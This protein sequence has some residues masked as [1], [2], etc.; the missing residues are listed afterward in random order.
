V[1]YIEAL[2]ECSGAGPEPKLFLAGGITGC[3]DWQ[4]EVVAKLTGVDNLVLLNPRR[5][6]WPIDNPDESTKQIKWE[7]AHLLRADAILFW[8]PRETVC[9]IA[10]FELGSWLPRPKPVFVGTHTEYSRRMDV[11]VQCGLE[12]PGLKVVHSLDALCE[13]VLEWHRKKLAA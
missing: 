7:H 11:V 2:E 5:K 9:P 4:S 1:K 12:R 3:H 10:L 8:F 13:Q 6:E